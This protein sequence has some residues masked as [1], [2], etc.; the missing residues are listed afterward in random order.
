MNVF[1]QERGGEKDGAGGWQ[2]DQVEQSK[3]GQSRRGLLN[4][5]GITLMPRIKALV[6]FEDSDSA[7][8]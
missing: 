7:I 8:Q 1:S 3:L 6:T 4:C 2:I 5:D